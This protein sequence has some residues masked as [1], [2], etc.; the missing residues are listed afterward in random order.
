MVAALPLTFAIEPSITPEGADQ[1]FVMYGVPWDTYVALNDALGDSSGVRVCYLEGTLELMSPGVL[2]EDKKTQ[3]ARLLE[4][5]SFVH[6]VPL[7]GTGS[8]T[9][10]RKPR[11][12]G[13]E[14]DESHFVGRKGKEGEA[15]DLAIEVAVSRSAIDKLSLYAGLGVRELWIWQDDA[16]RVFCLGKAGYRESKRSRVL[17]TLDMEELVTFVRMDDQAAAVKAYHKRLSKGRR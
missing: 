6:D 2:H 10:R 7:Y 5:W 17:P 3:T 8:T 14:P 11:E 15:P 9:L 1:R 4:M 16:I 13:A 12:R